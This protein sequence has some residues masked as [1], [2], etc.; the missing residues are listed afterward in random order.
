[1][2]GKIK[3]EIPLAALIPLTDVRLM[4]GIAKSYY[5]Q[6]Y[7]TFRYKL[8]KNI[9]NDIEISEKIRRTLGNEVRL[10]VDYNQAYT[11]EEAVRAIK[12]IEPFGIDFAEQP[13]K[14]DDYIGMAYVQQR[15]N[16]PLMAHEGFFNLRDFI[17]LVEL[18]AVGVLGINS[19]RPG[20]VTN[21]LEAIVYADKRGI[22]TVIHNQPLGIAS[23][24]HIHMAAAKYNS[25]GYATELFG[26]VMLE[27]DLIVKPL[28][29]SKGV[30]KVPDGPG[31]GVILD[32]KALQKYSTNPTIAIE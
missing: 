28:D 9:Q 5:K 2:G 21:A 15:V 12:S 8:G 13:V 11:P 29:Y 18:N 22:S 25:L 31:W 14:A 10:R 17:T 23:A 16:T 6:G 30:A 32:E 27:D 26:H 20:G 19:E 7:R 4:V 1:M 24:M 3:N